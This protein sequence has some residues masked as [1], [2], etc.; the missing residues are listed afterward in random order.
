MQ[1]D[2][3]SSA[4]QVTQIVKFKARLVAKGITQ[5]SGIENTETFA[6]VA[7]KE[8]INVVLAIAATEDLKEEMWMQILLYCMAK[9]TKRSTQINQMN[10]MTKKHDEEVP[11]TESTVWTQTSGEKVEH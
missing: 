9:L 10:S 11:A 1:M 4:I 5:R 7:R 2:L 3:R 6:P 8:S